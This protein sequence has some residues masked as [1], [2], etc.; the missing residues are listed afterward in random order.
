MKLLR[1]V[2]LIFGGLSGLFILNRFYDLIP[3]PET[4]ILVVIVA[5]SCHTLLIILLGLNLFNKQKKLGL[6][7]LILF[8]LYLVI[9][10][11]IEYV[12]IKRTGYNIQ[13]PQA[14]KENISIPYLDSIFILELITGI[15]TIYLVYKIK[16][17]WSGYRLRQGG[18]ETNPKK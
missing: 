9:R 16:S 6:W 12:S 17:K 11:V 7:T 15:L 1:L 10:H 8:P 5:Y 18:L 2:A 13:F 14:T 4:I 3:H